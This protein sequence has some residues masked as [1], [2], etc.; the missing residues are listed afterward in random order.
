MFL[1]FLSFPVGVIPAR[2]TWWHLFQAFVDRDLAYL[3][4]SRVPQK[5]DGGSPAED[6][7]GGSREKNLP[8]AVPSRSWCCLREDGERMCGYCNL[9]RCRVRIRAWFGY[10]E[11]NEKTSETPGR[12]DASKL[13]VVSIHIVR[14]LGWLETKYTPI[15]SVLAS[16]AGISSE[17]SPCFCVE[18]SLSSGISCSCVKDRFLPVLRRDAKH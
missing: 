18:S 2:N 12:V 7:S 6:W 8:L 13:A 5:T 9:R 17:I 15:K 16:R 10:E 14:L 1:V 3:S 4:G 11:T